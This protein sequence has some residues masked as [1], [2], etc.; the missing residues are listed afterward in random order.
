M[1]API[2][3]SGISVAIRFFT[4]KYLINDSVCGS[5][6][7]DLNGQA[8][9]LENKCTAEFNITSNT[10]SCTIDDEST[11]IAVTVSATSDLGTGQESQPRIIGIIL[12]LAA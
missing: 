12:S 9:K 2:S 7:I 1:Q 5:K 10:S 3:V 11:N 8:C 4:V 6:E